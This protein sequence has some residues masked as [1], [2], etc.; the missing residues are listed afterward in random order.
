MQHGVQRKMLNRHERKGRNVLLEFFSGNCPEPKN[1]AL[2]ASVAVNF[3][4]K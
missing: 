4:T 1:V 2:V 3:I